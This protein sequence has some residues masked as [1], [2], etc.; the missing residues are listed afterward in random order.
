MA[1]EERKE[2]QY[3]SGW[4]ALP[5]DYSYSPEL[6]IGEG[7][8]GDTTRKIWAYTDSYKY[9]V[10]K[11]SY[12]V[13]LTTYPDT[14]CFGSP[15]PTADTTTGDLIWDNLPYED[16]ISMQE[17][18]VNYFVPP[19]WHGIVIDDNFVSDVFAGNIPVCELSGIATLSD[20]MEDGS[21]TAGER[22][23]NIVS[24]AKE[25]F[26]KDINYPLGSIIYANLANTMFN[27]NTPTVTITCYADALPQNVAICV[28]ELETGEYT[29]L[30]S[31]EIEWNDGVGT[32]TVPQGDN[33]ETFGTTVMNAFQNNEGNYFMGFMFPDWYPITYDDIE[34]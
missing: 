17:G 14:R 28:C 24:A 6:I 25:D 18:M 34:G 26:G 13:T 33:A 5:V 2:S 20:L 8:A 10:N 3:L 7:T 30:H 1:L 12:T 22:Y 9:V 31:T 11:S 27:T 29:F 19:V 23:D 21:T 4:C 15:T 16:N 32:F